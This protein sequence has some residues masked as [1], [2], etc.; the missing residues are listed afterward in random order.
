M[1]K[2]SKTEKY[3]VCGGP[4]RN[5][6]ILAMFEGLRISFLVNRDKKPTEDACVEYTGIEVVS[7]QWIRSSDDG[8]NRNV[9]NVRGYLYHNPADRNATN[10]QSGKKCK[11]TCCYDPKFRCGDLRIMP[12]FPSR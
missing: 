3:D 1:N 10:S 9:F 7:V 6:L 11:F 12:Q 8:G 4:S 5:A 2:M